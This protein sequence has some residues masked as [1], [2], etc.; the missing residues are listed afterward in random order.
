MGLCGEPIVELQGPCRDRA[1]QQQE[2]LLEVSQEVTEANGNCVWSFA[3][4]CKDVVFGKTY[5]I[6]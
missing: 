4:N 2:V 3:S 1:M 5:A 6:L